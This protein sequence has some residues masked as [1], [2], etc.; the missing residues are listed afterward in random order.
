MI[1]KLLFTFAFTLTFAAALATAPGAWRASGETLPSRL[2]R[3]PDAPT[4]RP[5]QRPWAPEDEELAPPSD[6][7]LPDLEGVQVADA[8]E[9]P[10]RRPTR[11]PPTSQ[12]TTLVS[13][14]P[15]LYQIIYLNE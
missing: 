3:A 7:A 4:C 10:T 5:C 8:P 2:P 6:Y 12:S 9:S 14:T 15:L 13:P 1:N 11:T